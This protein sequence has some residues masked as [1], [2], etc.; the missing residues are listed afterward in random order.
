MQTVN[1][2]EGLLNATERSVGRNDLCPCGSG[3]KYKKCCLHKGHDYPSDETVK[4]RY[5]RQY[6]I[7]LKE[8]ADVE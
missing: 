4:E 6:Q 1:H 5:L 3:L 8:S 2:S 7:R